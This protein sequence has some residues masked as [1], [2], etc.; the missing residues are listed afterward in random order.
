MHLGRTPFIATTALLLIAGAPA[1]PA[2][3]AA[4]AHAVGFDLSRPEIRHFVAAIAKRDAL[5]RRQ[6]LR[7]LRKAQPQPKIIELMSRPAERVLQW[8][9]Y[10]QL[11]VT[12]QRISDGVQF[13]LDHQSVLEQV[14]AAQGVPPQYLVAILGCETFYGRITG[15]DRV[16][17]SL[18]TLAFDYP[19][20]SDYFRGELE[21]FLLLTREEHLDP[22]RVKGSYSGA[23]GAP[24]FMPS[25]YRRYAVDASH[26]H[27][28]DLWNNWADVLA[29]IANY[30]RQN[31]WRPGEPVLTDARLDPEPTFQLDARGELASTIDEL[32]ALGVRVAL[33]MPG[34]TPA[35]LI[36]AEQ[37]E[38][39]AYR[40]AFENFRAITRYNH[41]ARYAMA[42]TDLAQGIAER[43]R[44][45]RTE[46]PP[47]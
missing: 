2:T 19:P 25:A 3:P 6:I 36:P 41:S 44:A 45:T 38:G 14:A 23:M 16:L 9:E 40:V 7:L 39:P 46:V 24:Q 34:S 20:R 29:S 17:D 32:N 4:T 22:L 27:R 8:W 26:D 47:S 42:V 10:R 30:L 15:R 43:V 28:R 1:V 33:S 31:G 11:F 18:A 21:Q 37:K 12:E 5:S 13:W 35:V